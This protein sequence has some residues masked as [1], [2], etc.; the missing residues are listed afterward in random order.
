MSIN[1]FEVFPQ[2]VHSDIKE[3]AH[4]LSPKSIRIQIEECNV[5]D[6]EEADG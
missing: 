6:V 4:E 1:H 2:G 5:S 3:D